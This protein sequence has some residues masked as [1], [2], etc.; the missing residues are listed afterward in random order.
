[1]IFLTHLWAPGQDM[2]KLDTEHSSKFT[3]PPNQIQLVD[4]FQ[5]SLYTSY[6][7]LD[8]S[9]PA[10]EWAKNIKQSVLTH[11]NYLLLW[12]WGRGGYRQ[13]KSQISVK[14]NEQESYG[15]HRSPE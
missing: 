7:V 11:C 13:I 3:G 1:M 14:T 6:I 5:V 12:G 2:V 8:E 4:D 9:P 15:P 10:I